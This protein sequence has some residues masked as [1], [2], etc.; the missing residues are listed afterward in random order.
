[1]STAPDRAAGAR[2]GIL[3]RLTRA[4]SRHTGL[5]VW[6]GMATLLTAGLVLSVGLIG[7]ESVVYLSPGAKTVT[8]V[9]LGLVIGAGLAWGIVRPVL[10]PLS[11]HV[12]ARRIETA[13]G[14][15]N[16]HL[17]NTL[18]LWDQRDQ[19]GS[20][21]EL[22]DAAIEQAEEATRSI[23]FSAAVDGTPAKTAARRFALALVVGLLALQLFPGSSIEALSRLA[24]PTE[25]YIRP[26]ETQL[27]VTPGDTALIVGDS[28]ILR[29]DIEGIVP[30]KA[31]LL[32]REEA[33]RPWTS[34]EVPIR[35]NRAA[36]GIPS[37]RRSFVYR[38]QV[39]DAESE[40]HTIL[41]KSAPSF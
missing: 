35:E 22:I 31:L 24:H 8:L 7:I 14:G 12:M 18:Q 30:L 40:T 27:T 38:W 23:D 34:I 1:M 10:V 32:S 29:A 4:R 28:L 26:R 3:T 25:R 17:T 41:A 16:Q 15:L 6:R 9:L 19:S 13:H 36:H 33:D 2:Q 20:S 5:H 39:H 11:L 21:R 37:V